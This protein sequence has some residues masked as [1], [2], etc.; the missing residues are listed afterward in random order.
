CNRTELYVGAEGGV[1]PELGEHALGWL[2]QS[3][4][5]EAPALRPH[6]YVLEGASAARHTFRLASGL[7]SMVVGE[8]QILGQLKQAVR[9]AGT[10]GTLGTTLHQLFQRSFAVAKEVRSGTAIGMHTVSMAAAIVRLG[11]ELFGDFSELK[12]LFIG[13]GE[14]ASPVLTHVAAQAP[15]LLTIANRTLGRADALAENFGGES[16]GLVE[17]V[18]RLAEFDI[19]VSCTAS[20]LPLVGLGAVESAIKARRR[21]PMLMVD[22]AV[23]RD[24]E[25]EVAR[26]EDVYLYTV[27]DLARIVQSGADKRSAAVEQAET[28]IES[29]VH[30]F[31]RWLETRR[32][33]PLIQALQGAAEGWRATELQRARK[34]LAKGEDVDVVLESLSRGLT[35]RMLHGPMAGLQA[36]EEAERPALAHALA[37]LY[38][39]CPMRGRR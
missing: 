33:V 26:I 23:P 9:E 4:G 12:V 36:A 10:A 35:Q 39:Q 15:A 3:G 18:A 29:G 11:D 28:I 17:A 25:P 7:S 34:S 16:V 37:R 21:R 2:A 32:S 22:L 19:V 30:D 24:I 27:D 1:T 20:P 13:A 6:A 14:M 5:L 38:L 8:T 31:L